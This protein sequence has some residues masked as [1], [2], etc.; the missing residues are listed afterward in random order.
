MSPE[1]TDVDLEELKFVLKNLRRP[2]KIGRSSLA[3][4]PSV[5]REIK[6]LHLIDSPANRGFV[7]IRL[8]E[9][10]IIDRLQG[11]EGRATDQAVA[12]A[13]L[14]LLYVEHKTIKQ[15][16]KELGI[17]ERSVSRVRDEGVVLLGIV[18]LEDMAKPS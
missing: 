6:R 15:I 8:I 18:L 9:D 12:W 2:A 4:V 10:T 1:P 3:A 7:L 17:S 5:S 11:L 16:S 13:C 14:H